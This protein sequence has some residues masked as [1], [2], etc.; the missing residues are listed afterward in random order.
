MK[1]HA[2]SRR[3]LLQAGTAA[4][5]SALAP[6]LTAANRTGQ[7]TVAPDV[8]VFA[9]QRRLALSAS[10]DLAIVEFGQRAVL[11]SG[12]STVPLQRSPQTPT[13][14]SAPH[15]VSGCLLG[16][17][18]LLLDRK[19]RRIDRFSTDGQF[20]DSLPLAALT[21]RPASL[22]AHGEKLWLTDSAAHRVLRLD[23]RGR[24]EDAF[25]GHPWRRTSLNGPSSLSIDMA[26][27]LHI[28]ET[29]HRRVSVW[30]PDGL[31][32]GEYA[33]D[34]TPGARGLAIDATRDSLLL[35]DSWERRAR[36]FHAGTGREIP[37]APL[38]A[39]ACAA[40]LSCL[41]FAQ[42]KGFYLAT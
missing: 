42:G 5:L 41:S 17:T 18:L 33:T 9:D 35:V 6:G 21:E 29:G 27:H 2:F 32:L 40:P 8:T 4:A 31:Y 10:L 13:L 30:Q 28:L 24:R 19:H 22:H 7:A 16:G 36:R 34:I 39:S 23:P 26:G 25:G 14:V 38:L 12:V 20:R 1:D 37:D 11:V 15:Y 3:T